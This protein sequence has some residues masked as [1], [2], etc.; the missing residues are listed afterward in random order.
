MYWKIS[1][2]YILLLFSC[3]SE[4]SSIAN[5]QIAST[6]GLRSDYLIEAEELK[7]IIGQENIKVIDFRKRED[8]DKKHIAGA[9][10]IWRSDIE[11]S[12]YSYDGM[13]A[14]PAQIETLFSELGISNQ[15]M[16]VIY[17]DN[18]LC[19]AARLW[20]VLQNY[21]FINVKLLNGGLQEW[22]M[23]DGPTSRENTPFSKTTFQLTDSPSMKYY[24][25]K[26]ELIKSVERDLIIVDTRSASEY[27]GMVL[28]DGAAKRGRIPNSIHLDWIL[29]I[30]LDKNKKLKTMEELRAIYQQIDATDHRPLVVYCHSGVRSA[31][32]TFV[33]TQLL[34]F[35][36][37]RNYDGSWVEWSH[38]NDL[39]FET[40]SITGIIK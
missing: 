23:R 4:N 5:D 8:F 37:V 13:M 36:N 15:D 7:Q 1:L 21:D 39:K 28:K 9:L 32:T 29:A 22:I 35:Q 26:D 11:D 31:H 27:S 16:L 14:S 12:S 33:L 25:S 38:F 3:K 20:W 24:I 40:D 30:D 6:T 2:V 10:N 19:D 17:D 18:G 34:G